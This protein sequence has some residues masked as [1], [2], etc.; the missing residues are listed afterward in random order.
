M[1]DK[2]DITNDSL[3]LFDNV[4]SIEND[5]DTIMIEADEAMTKSQQ[6]KNDTTSPID[7]YK[8]TLKKWTDCTSFQRIGSITLLTNNI[9]N[10]LNNLI[11]NKSNLII[12]FVTETNHSFGVFE[13][14]TIPTCE[15]GNNPMYS[16][17]VFGF[18]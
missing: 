12:L 8:T 2:P 16:L 15:R 7:N 14:R 6:E 17:N 1:T 18:V 5:S 13:S 10:K 4:E 11:C 9:K 3:A